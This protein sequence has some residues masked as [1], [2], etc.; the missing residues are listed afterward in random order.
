[1]SYKVAKKSFKGNMLLL[2][3]DGAKGK[4]YFLSTPV[5]AYAKSSGVEVGTEV[6]DI[7]TE[8][9]GKDTYITKLSIKGGSSVKS[10]TNDNT[11]TSSG[12]SNGYRPSY[13]SKSPEE[14]EKITRLSVLSSVATIL[15]NVAFDNAEATIKEADALFDH[16]LTKIRPGATASSPKAEEEIPF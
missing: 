2:E 10:P 4:W 3:K 9:R 16:F 15:S 7:Q 12:G 5:E 1:M 11:S 8:Q 14:S 13:G 6:E